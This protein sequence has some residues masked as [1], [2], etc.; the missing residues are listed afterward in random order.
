M[1][2]RP[3]VH[4]RPDRVGVLGRYGGHSR[5]LSRC[6]ATDIIRIVGN[7]VAEPCL[8]C[9]VRYAVASIPLKLRTFQRYSM[10]QS[11]QSHRYRNRQKYRSASGQLSPVNLISEFTVAA[12]RFSPDLRCKEIELTYRVLNLPVSH[13]R[14]VVLGL[15]F[16]YLYIYLGL[17]LFLSH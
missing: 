1:A 10:T 12:G 17:I 9:G 11:G 5:S 6:R 2:L 7:P 15:V 13:Q 3:G 14:C 4:R 16:L 8:R